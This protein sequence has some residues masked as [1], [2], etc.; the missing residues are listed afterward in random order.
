MPRYTSTTGIN[1]ELDRFSIGVNVESLILNYWKRF[2]C[3]PKSTLV[4]HCY[5]SLLDNP[6]PADLC[7][8]FTED[9][10]FLQ[11]D[12]ITFGKKK[13][14][15]FPSH[16]KFLSKRF[17]YLKDNIKDHF[18]PKPSSNLHPQSALVKFKNGK[19]NLKL[20]NYLSTIENRDRRKLLAELR[21]AV[22]PLEIKKG[23]LSDLD[24]S[25]TFCN[26]NE[27]EDEPHFL[28]ELPLLLVKNIPILDLHLF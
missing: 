20:Y 28:V 23:M 25:L 18:I 15:F 8:H 9:T 10:I 4:W 11:Q 1:I 12:D 26:C 13:K 5:W 3:L 14:D 21:L 16:H 17:I 6:H 22:L 7:L 24:T 2:I 27:N 19:E